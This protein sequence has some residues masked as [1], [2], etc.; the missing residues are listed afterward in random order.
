MDVKWGSQQEAGSKNLYWRIRG[1][2]NVALCS[3][4]PIVNKQNGGRLN[5]FVKFC[6]RSGEK[7]SLFQGMKLSKVDQESGEA[8]QKS[9]FSFITSTAAAPPVDQVQVD[10][11]SITETTTTSSVTLSSRSVSATSQ[12]SSPPYTFPSGLSASGATSGYSSESS[13]TTSS[14]R[15]VTR[16]VFSGVPLP[17]SPGVP[18]PASTGVPL[19]AS[20]G[21]P[22]PA[23]TGVPLPTSTGVP[24][25]ASTGDTSP[26]DASVVKLTGPGT[27]ITRKKR[28]ISLIRP[29]YARQD[30]ST[31]RMKT[32]PDA[33]DLP[34]LK[35]TLRVREELE[36][37]N[38]QDISL[39]RLSIEKS[40]V[41]SSK[42]STQERADTL[43]LDERTSSSSEISR[44]CH[45]A[46][47]DRANIFP[48]LNNK[49]QTEENLNKDKSSSSDPFESLT[50]DVADS[51]QVGE[52]T[53]VSELESLSLDLSFDLDF[54]LDLDV[55]MPCSTGP[56]NVQCNS[57]TET[58]PLDGL[59]LDLLD[60]KADEGTVNTGADSGES[61]SV[62]N[63]TTVTSSFRFLQSADVTKAAEDND[64][65]DLEIE[66]CT[67]KTE[68]SHQPVGRSEVEEAEKAAGDDLPEETVIRKQDVNLGSDD[69]ANDSLV[70]SE[71]ATRKEDDLVMTDSMVED[72]QNSRLEEVRER[73]SHLQQQH[74][75]LLQT[76]VKLCCRQ[77]KKRR[78]LSRVKAEQDQAVKNEDYEK[79][80]A[81]N[82]RLQSLTADLQAM[83]FDLPSS[84]PST[85]SLLEEMRHVMEEEVAMVTEE[86]ERYTAMKTKEELCLKELHTTKQVELNREKQKLATLQDQLAMAASHLSLDRE[87]LQKSKA[88]L[89]SQVE[90]RTAEFHT[91]REQ[92]VEKRQDIQEEISA[93]EERLRVLRQQEESISAEI[94]LQEDSISRVEQQFSTERVQLEEERRTIDRKQGELED[95]AR[96]A[97][98]EEQTLR[99]REVE[100]QIEEKRLQDSLQSIQERVSHMTSQAQE[101]S[102]RAEDMMAL[103]VYTGTI[104]TNNQQI[105]RLKEQQQERQREVQEL[106]TQVL[107]YQTRVT[108]LTKQLGETAAQMPVLQEAKQLA[109][110][111]YNFSEA[112]RLAD[113]IKT[114]EDKRV[115]KEKELVRAQEDV[116]QQTQNLEMSK[117]VFKEVQEELKQKEE[118]N[119][120]V[121][122][123]EAYQLYQELQLQLDRCANDVIRSVLQADMTA[124][125][126]WIQDICEKHH[127][128][129]PQELQ[130]LD[131]QGILGEDDDD[132]VAMDT[133]CVGDGGVL[134]ATGPEN[135]EAPTGG[136]CAAE[137]HMQA[138]E[139][140]GGSCQAEDYVQA[141]EAFSM[142][143][144]E[145][146]DQLQEAVGQEDYEAAQTL[147]EEIQTLK[148]QLQNIV[149]PDCSEVASRGTNQAEYTCMKHFSSNPI[150]SLHS[151]LFSDCCHGLMAPIVCNS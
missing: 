133:S 108:D 106:T 76:H 145:L 71:V 45:P 134:K 58:G 80:E 136:S 41:S 38:D 131:L 138:C 150:C 127:L 33:D 21:V 126:L 55:T 35:S 119:D 79:A 112:K 12:V 66:S 151:V 89:S 85:A 142:R 147:H 28:H 137:D 51:E 54:N 40:K 73:F 50:L 47:L 31:E 18:L 93:L 15:A 13:S 29:G 3:V 78:E 121:R 87:H 101:L 102:T 116:E 32:D 105:T 100:L 125:Q 130:A 77:V 146:E 90:E 26:R 9:L 24:L 103:P 6:R 118:E 25:P 144:L 74:Q 92:L 22:L 94:Q 10:K 107:R 19:P 63:T 135:K 56:D 52:T 42:L 83:T 30:T 149:V 5:D 123:D 98:Q 68:F 104:N 84:E 117:K 111:G 46:K 81:F 128:P 91:A 86:A 67:E 34:V 122:K 129:L 44:D 139:A 60:P 115:A 11:S 36:E 4:P 99:D 2:T 57:D 124:C 69:T 95:Q 114:L 27:K 61:S 7:M 148:H 16:P 62:Q 8:G 96:E 53:A 132:M 39:N 14:P 59:E 37:S 48:P 20:T 82:R 88:Q 110:A 97:A 43:R 64:D 140:A 23:S 141:C 49:T 109:V 17:V 113:E 75:T 72:S 1:H 120:A 70:T 65:I 143:L